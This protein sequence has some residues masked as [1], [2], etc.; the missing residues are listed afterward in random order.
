MPSHP[1]RVRRQYDLT[2]CTCVV[3]TGGHR[4]PTSAGCPLHPVA[5]TQSLTQTTDTGFT[6]NVIE[7]EPDDSW[8]V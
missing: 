3:V 2:R 5:A 6:L 7:G 8:G 4:V 1:D